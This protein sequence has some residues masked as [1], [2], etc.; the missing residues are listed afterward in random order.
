MIKR[1]ISRK[2]ILSITL[3][4]LL[5]SVIFAG[6][7]VAYFASETGGLNN[8]I[9]PGRVN[10]G[11]VLGDEA[12]H[13]EDVVPGNIVTLSLEDITK[14]V[15]F[16]NIFTEAYPTADTY[17]RV[18]LVGIWKDSDGYGT[19]IEVNPVYSLDSNNLEASGEWKKIGEYYYYKDF[20]E[21]DEVSTV[22]FNSVSFVEP[23]ESGHMEVQ[24]L[25]DGVIADEDIIED[26]WGINLS[27]LN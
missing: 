23:D 18:R 13:Y 16:K 4:L 26:T 9:R 27:D 20:L 24:V 7:T 25:I 10:V 12:T 19:G 15:R 1:L 2:K 22:L 21:P 3:I 11:V 6:G 5:T 14:G 17:V 8:I